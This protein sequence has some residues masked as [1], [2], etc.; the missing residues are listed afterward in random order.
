MVPVAGIVFDVGNG[1]WYATEGD[2]VAMGLSLA[3]AIPIAGDI[4]EGAKLG[5][6]AVKVGEEVA[7]GARDASKIEKVVEGAGNTEK[8]YHYTSASPESILK[9]GLQ[10]G[11]SGKVFTTPAGNLSLLQAQ[12][13]LALPPNRGL[14]K[15][16][17]EIDVQTLRNMGIEIPQGQQVTRMFNM[18]GGGTEVVFPHAIPPEAIKLIK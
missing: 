13:D 18:P 2:Y 6:K 9:S 8:L 10:P 15:N 7:E 5:Y 1:I 3:G 11:S 12:I 17:L 16:L 4:A 14:P